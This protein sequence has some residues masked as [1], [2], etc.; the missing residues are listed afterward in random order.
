MFG[1]GQTDLL[2]DVGRQDRLV[3]IN[4]PADLPTAPVP[5]VVVYHGY[6]GTAADAAKQ[7]GLS[8]K[9]EAEGFRFVAVYPQG[10]DNEWHIAGYPSTAAFGDGDLQLFLA[11]LDRV[12]ESGCIDMTHVYVTGHSQG[13][14]MASLLACTFADRVAAVAPVAGESLELPCKPSRPIPIVA[15]HSRE[16]PTLL[17]EGGHIPHTS[18]SFPD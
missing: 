9:G 18:S 8:A 6:G 15:F 7:T 3:V 5:L 10:I 14:G 13:G 1:I 16:D 12:A 11:V 2:L 17:Y 4:V